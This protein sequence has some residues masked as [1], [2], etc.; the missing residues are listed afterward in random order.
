MLGNLPNVTQ[1]IVAEVALNRAHDSKWTLLT[2]H[3]AASPSGI[4]RTR[5]HGHKRLAVNA[6]APPTSGA[7]RRFPLQG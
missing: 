4:T 6:E 7:I 5:S 3:P 2:S 1:Q